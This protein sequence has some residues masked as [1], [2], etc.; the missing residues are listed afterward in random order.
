MM[1]W[2]ELVYYLINI[3]LIYTYHVKTKLFI[4]KRAAPKSDTQYSIPQSA[5]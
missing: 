3:I 5:N 4:V 1:K 2:L